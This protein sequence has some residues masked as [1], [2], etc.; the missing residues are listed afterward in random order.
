MER[1]IGL[2]VHSTTCTCVVLGPSG[3]KTKQVVLETKVK[4]LRELMRGVRRPSVLVME[5]GNQSEWLFEVLSPHVTETLVVQPERSAGHKND[6]LDAERLARVARRGEPGRMIYKAPRLLAPLR[7]ATKVYATVKKD[8][9]RSRARLK[10]LLQSRGLL[11][12]SQQL[13]EQDERELW[14]Q[15]L[16]EALVPRARILAA[17]IDALGKCYDDAHALLLA[18]SRGV[19]AI[20]WVKSVPGFGPIRAAET[21]SAIITP[22]RFRTKRQLWSYSRLAV[23]A[24]S[25]NDWVPDGRGGLRRR[26]R[27]LVLGLNRNGNAAL[28]S[29]FV[30]AAQHIINAMSGHPLHKGYQA[31]IA[32]GMKPSSARLTLA[33]QL[34]A[35]VLAI[36]KKEQLYDATKSAQ[37]TR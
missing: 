20:R 5:E 36:W 37:L 1:Y 18:Q 19:R 2:D 35:I 7:Q 23:L 33:R 24:H 25:S 22:H 30:G 8:W 21:V 14:L 29:A 4:E 32:R 12:P 34:A 9:M 11:A 3:R 13:L 28:K 26:H 17:Q 6:A 31:R 15:Q 27:E 16:P 10:L